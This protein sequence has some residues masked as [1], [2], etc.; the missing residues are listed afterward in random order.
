MSK[1]HE[2]LEINPEQPGIP[3]L[4]A[5]RKGVRKIWDEVSQTFREGKAKPA[6]LDPELRALPSELVTPKEI[7]PED[8]IHPEDPPHIR[9]A[10]VEEFVK[11]VE[12]AERPK[13]PEEKIEAA[14]HDPAFLALAQRFSI[15]GPDARLGDAL[16]TQERVDWIRFSTLRQKLNTAIANVKQGLP[17]SNQLAWLQNLQ[18]LWFPTPDVRHCE[19]RER[20]PPHDILRPGWLKGLDLVC[21][22]N[23]WPRRIVDLFM[24][25]G[26]K[27]DPFEE[28]KKELEWAAA[29]RELY[30]DG[31]EDA[32]DAS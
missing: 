28:I 19:V 1:E 20:L 7:E 6:L 12:E 4:P 16:I 27:L 13:K 24:R 30:G 32:D 11:K 21:D 5:G 15:P 29:V 3:G 22:I 25:A 9:G 31:E 14:L 17:A 10:L 18:H 26:I 23:T 8:K 2:E